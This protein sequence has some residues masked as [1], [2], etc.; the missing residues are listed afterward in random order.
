[1]PVTNEHF[2]L[3]A[4]VWRKSTLSAG[5][6]SV[7]VEA[8]A[9]HVDGT[10]PVLA[11]I[12]DVAG[13]L[14]EDA[15]AWATAHRDRIEESVQRCGAVLIRG[16]AITS[17]T[18]FRAVCAAIRPDLRNY[19]GGDS[20]RTGVADQVYTSTE[21]PAHLEVY[22]HNELSYAGWSPD[23]LFFCCL[24]PSE[25]G[26]ET[27]LADGREI[28]GALD[29][30]VRGRFEARGVTYLQHL[31]D[32]S[33]VPG[34]GKSWQETFETGDRAA[35]ERYLDGAG[36]R[37]DWTR[38]G[39]RTAA[40]HPAIL[41]HPVTGERCWHNQADQ[42]HRGIPGVK[43]SF[44]RSGTGG[45]DAHTAGVETLGNHVTYGDGSEIDVEDLMHVR[46]VSHTC[47]AKFSWQAGDV[48]V[49]DNVLAMH[50][51]KPFTGPRRV[52]AA[53]A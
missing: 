14:V 9:R 53:M 17:A 20:P 42:W 49:I 37:F 7:N 25:T 39:L 8:P 12:G 32:A 36:M 26:G 16:F 35:V 23:R 4:L 34:I 5:V 45:Y 21:Y 30:A 13:R 15:V 38:L 48:L 41:N 31:W 22:L 6:R 19:A 51:R 1:M 3:A 24:I 27:H 44:G 10:L 46:S 40:D 28:L 11:E 33:G 18:E 43:V 29:P 47:E 2:R 50:G 52:L